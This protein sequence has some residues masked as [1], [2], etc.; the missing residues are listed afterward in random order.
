M[1]QVT[2]QV[3]LGQHH[4]AEKLKRRGLLLD[5]TFV[6]PIH[7]DHEWQRTSHTFIDEDF[8]SIAL[9]WGQW[10]MLANSP[11]ICKSSASFFSTSSTALGDIP[12]GNIRDIETH[13]KFVAAP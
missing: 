9:T 4:E 2:N 11:A 5:A 3:S 12:V 7:Y 10:F 8:Q 6:E 1:S 13:W